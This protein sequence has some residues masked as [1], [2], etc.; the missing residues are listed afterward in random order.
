MNITPTLR[1]RNDSVT[2]RFVI[3]QKARMPL[4]VAGQRGGLVFTVALQRRMNLNEFG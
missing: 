3:R 4:G 2:A 1:S